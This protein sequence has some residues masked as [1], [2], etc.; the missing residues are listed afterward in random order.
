MKANDVPSEDSIIIS[1]ISSL[2]LALVGRLCE[3]LMSTIYSN[4]VEHWLTFLYYPAH[5]LVPDI[6][7]M[8]FQHLDSRQKY[9]LNSVL[10]N[11]H[12]LG[13]EI[14]IEKHEHKSEHLNGQS[15]ALVYLIHLS[16]IYR[17]VCNAFY[18]FTVCSCEICIS[19]IFQRMLSP[20]KCLSPHIAQCLIQEHT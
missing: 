14:L 3:T 8:S 6:R 20:R 2:S 4:T 9:H 19:F 18:S 15:N 17:L 5:T 11:L 12:S 7:D 10:K 13:E 1:S 16:L